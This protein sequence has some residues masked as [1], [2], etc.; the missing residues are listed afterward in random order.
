MADS[1]QYTEATKP[2]GMLGGFGAPSALPNAQT[3]RLYQGKDI[4]QHDDIAPGR[5]R[6]DSFAHG[7]VG[8]AKGLA[9][10]FGK[11]PAPTDGGF[12]NTTVY[13]A[14]QMVGST[15]LGS[16]IM[17]G[18]WGMGNMIGHWVSNPIRRHWITPDESRYY[19]NV[20]HQHDKAMEV[21]HK[22]QYYSTHPNEVP[23]PNVMGPFHSSQEIMNAERAFYKIHYANSQEIFGWQ[24][25]SRARELQNEADSKLPGWVQGANEL[26][27]GYSGVR[28]SV[29][30]PKVLGAASSSFDSLQHLY[31]ETNLAFQKHGAE[32]ATKVL[33][34]VIGA[35]I[36]GSLIDPA[37][38]EMMGLGRQA[39]M[40]ATATTIRSAGERAAARDAMEGAAQDINNLR[41]PGE[42]ERVTQ[43]VVDRAWTQVQNELDPDMRIRRGLAPKTASPEDVRTLFHQKLDEAFAP[44]AQVI[45][46]SDLSLANQAILRRQIEMHMDQAARLADSRL[47]SALA[48]DNPVNFLI[49]ENPVEL[50]RLYDEYVSHLT[51]NGVEATAGGRPILNFEQWREHAIARNLISH[52]SR[53]RITSNPDLY[54]R[55]LTDPELAISQDR[56]QQIVSKHLDRMDELKHQMDTF[57][58]RDTPD[59]ETFAPAKSKIADEWL[60]LYRQ[61]HP[62]ITDEEI[63]GLKHRIM[64]KDSDR[65]PVQPDH[66][67]HEVSRMNDL[68]TEMVHDLYQDGS[69]ASM[70]SEK[71]YFYVDEPVREWAH[72]WGKM[73]NYPLGRVEKLVKAIKDGKFDPKPLTSDEEKLLEQSMNKE[74]G[75]LP[76]GN[77]TFPRMQS[78]WMDKFHNDARALERRKMLRGELH[79]KALDENSLPVVDHNFIDELH[80]RLDASHPTE[81]HETLHDKVTRIGAEATDRARL[82]AES[83]ETS[84]HGADHLR[85]LLNRG[86]ISEQEFQE[87]MDQ[88][89]VDYTEAKFRYEERPFD[90]AAADHYQNLRRNDRNWFTSYRDYLRDI[91]DSLPA[92]S[93]AQEFEDYL[94]SRANRMSSAYER[95]QGRLR[96]RGIWYQRIVTGATAVPK[97]GFRAINRA[98]TSYS[99]LGAQVASAFVHPYEDIWQESKKA[100][101]DVSTLG[102][103]ISE[104][105]GLGQNSF[106]S[107]AIDGIVSLMEAPIPALKAATETRNVEGEVGAVTSFD[108]DNALE[109]NGNYRRALK[110][111]SNRTAG[112]IIDGFPQLAHVAL[113]IQNMSA[114]AIHNE[115]RAILTANDTITIRRL[116]SIG[117]YGQIKVG[118]KITDQ[119]GLRFWTRLFSV[120]PQIIDEQ[121]MPQRLEHIVLGDVSA[122]PAI[123]QFMRQSKF[124]SRTIHYVTQHLLENPGDHEAWATALFNTFHEKFGGEIDR[125]YL[126][127]HGLNPNDSSGPM[128]VV[129]SIFAERDARLSRAL[130]DDPLTGS[131]DQFYAEADAQRALRKYFDDPALQDLYVGMHHSIHE[132]LTKLFQHNRAGGQL[133]GF[134]VDGSPLSGLQRE[135]FTSAAIWFSQRSRFTLPNYRNVNKMT[136]DL[137][138]NF[139]TQTKEEGLPGETPTRGNRFENKAALF[140]LTKNNQINHWVNDSFFKP[141]ALLSPGWALRVSGSELGLNAARVGPSQLVAGYASQNMIR[142]LTKIH[143]NTT[144]DILRMTHPD[145]VAAGLAS[146]GIQ[147]SRHWAIKLSNEARMA[148]LQ[149]DRGILRMVDKEEYIN[150]AVYMAYRH[151][152]NYLPELLDSKH[153]VG[154][155]AYVPKRDKA[156][157]KK[158]EKQRRYKYTGT[159]TAAEYA[160]NPFDSNKYVEGW[161]FQSHQIAAD[162]YLGRP[163]ALAY[164]HLY[165]SGLRGM[166]LSVAAEQAARDILVRIPPNIRA[167]MERSSNRGLVGEFTDTPQ[168]S[169][170][171]TAVAGLEGTVYGPS[172]KGFNSNL[173]ANVGDRVSGVRTFHRDLLDNIAHNE[174]PETSQAFEEQFMH[175]DV[176][177]SD[178]GQVERRKYNKENLPV[179]VMT[180]DMEKAFGFS[181]MIQRLSTVGHEKLLGPMVNHMVRQPLYIVEW[182]NARKALEKGVS[183]GRFSSDQAD[184]LAEVHASQSMIKFI[185]NP[186]DKTKFEEILRTVAPF[187]FA[188]NQA[189]RRAGRLFA[190]DPGAFL[191]YAIGM[192]GVTNW[193]SQSMNKNGFNVLYVPS[194]VL[195]IG[196]IAFGANVDS[197]MTMDP[198]AEGVDP[199][200]GRF[201]FVDLI[202]SMSLP[203]FGPVATIPTHMITADIGWG[204]ISKHVD[205]SEFGKGLQDY[206]LGPIGTHT[207]LW[208][209][210]MPNSFLRNTMIGAAGALDVKFDPLHGSGDPLGLGPQYQQV[211][212]E[213]TRG[214]FTEGSKKAYEDA[215]KKGLRGD[216]LKYAVA[217]WVKSIDPRIDPEGYQ[218]FI[219]QANVRAAELWAVKMS[220]GLVTPFSGSLGKADQPLIDQYQASM[221]KYGFPKGMEM[222]YMEHPYATADMIASSKA[223]TTSWY[224]ETKTVNDIVENHSD[225]IKEFPEAALCFFHIG[226][227]KGKGYVAASANYIDAGLREHQIPGDFVKKVLVATG[228]N[229]Y[230]DVVKKGVDDRVAKGLMTP[231]KRTVFL[232]DWSN[233]YATN[234]NATWKTGTTSPDINHGVQLTQLNEMLKIPKYRDSPEGK[235]IQKFM[236]TPGGGLMGLAD[237]TALIKS[238]KSNSDARKKYWQETC[239][240]W[241]QHYPALKPAMD[242]MFRNFA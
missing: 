30:L 34:P 114:E 145:N 26:L 109:Q 42:A 222:F 94:A 122:V 126:A 19:N 120:S 71:N 49:S 40:D 92:D 64:G 242:T 201:S 111:L 12:K 2:G 95:S 199:N 102:R 160:R 65:L 127:A 146:R 98:T 93:R 129:R 151:D 158:G 107:G 168:E 147:V 224:P 1:K 128:A 196:N 11:A 186:K 157:L 79:Q 82:R 185:H 85:G 99:S 171:K 142:Q 84:S 46:E 237:V 181:E 218:H 17:D 70:Q 238:G 180:R 15:R 101:K 35:G 241:V 221:K 48:E 52:N 200:T 53:P 20:D 91:G 108:L 164:L 138:D 203:K 54:D 220:I 13:N 152:G 156:V 3:P 103:G 27:S 43:N 183:L 4:Y 130:S 215:W 228:N 100:T 74:R 209:A 216:D 144:E 231:G 62:H 29:A 69:E 167:T 87:M 66:L 161:H 10:E 83:I 213:S 104:A 197:A 223:T 173:E 207:A 25:D 211:V 136:R 112:E 182:V 226:N 191:Q 202:K 6:W 113:R 81:V 119:R 105:V 153:N 214:L 132:G 172:A 179:H 155:L 184:V 188:Q 233:W 174:L 210:A 227:P 212:V 37:G 219:S 165:D 22:A 149:V 123:G 192:I 23:P 110:A 148:M 76:E 96:A 208:A 190:K 9:Y 45:R 18:I 115:L 134:N 116:P 32:G 234:Y 86:E 176:V 194:T 170:A 162:E 198:F 187:Y 67:R 39:A 21:I 240:W 75:V 61:I 141:L 239:D 7:A 143:G 133:Y 232:R 125:A 28:M 51:N 97:Y 56:A 135:D 175:H 229:I 68:V 195:S 121:G 189:W 206:I 77:G 118:A 16:Q 225:V 60:E 47:I 73:H 5:E 50:H 217:T 166:Q 89:R 31:R 55:P 131:E 117:L 137:F 140:F 154:D 41:I 163:L 193:I 159:Y 80:E 106:L 178:T 8:V 57:P 33:A 139:V 204:H 36:I 230:Y 88:L 38:G 58:D 236:N 90:A 24:P 205:E 63:A 44:H 150:A 59:L 169:W 14:N 78:R 177:N 72:L 124:D 235:A